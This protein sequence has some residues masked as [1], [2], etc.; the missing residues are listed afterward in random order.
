LLSIF[1]IWGS[2]SKAT[3]KCREPAV[4]SVNLLKYFTLVG[5]HFIEFA[6]LHSIG[7][8]SHAR[9]LLTNFRWGAG[10]LIQITQSLPGVS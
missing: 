3:Y 7:D 4:I 2:F 8:R 6:N 10:V 9:T 1:F 5:T